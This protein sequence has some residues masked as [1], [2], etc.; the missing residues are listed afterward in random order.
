MNNKMKRILVIGACGQIGSELTL[1]LRKRYGNE[2]V[3]AADLRNNPSSSLTANG[4]IFEILD[5]MN[6]ER[7]RFLIEK[8]SIDSIFH[9]AAIL[10]AAGENNPNLCWDININGSLNVLNLG[11]EFKLNRIIIPSSMAC[12]GKFVEKEN[13]KQ[14][15]V[16]HPTS[17][18]GITKVAGELLCDY[19]VHKF[20]LDC[21]GLRYPG[22]ISHETLPGGGT[23]DY[24]VDIF[25]SAVKKEKYKCFLSENTMLP[26]MF[27]SDCI[28]ATIDLAEADFDKL[29]HH[30]NFN[31][32]AMSFTPKQL[33]E[34]IK[35]FKPDFE[36]EYC[37]DFRQKIAD[38]WVYSIDDSV[39]RSEWNWKPEYDITSMTKR[40]LDVL[41]EK[42][43]NGLIK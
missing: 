39:A 2:N 15:S 22:I 17:M 4:G 6:V 18:Y 43:K 1:E 28:K 42:Y 14:D 7:L 25:Y 34:E 41:T 33:F 8:Y 31:V 9:L 5:V 38:S 24:A 27:M 30:S 3:V 21:R 37:P 10:S 12:W 36:I 23:T 16:L 19:Y 26:M 29:I 35:K 11:V 32:A 13:V 20:G 40:M